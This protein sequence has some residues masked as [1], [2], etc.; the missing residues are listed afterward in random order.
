MPL[1]NKNFHI[2]TEFLS[3]FIMGPTLV[4][5]GSKQTKYTYKYILYLFAL[6][7]FIIDGYLLLQ[8]NKW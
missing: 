6:L 5:I 3:V 1:Q 8:Y 7:I 4:Y 2:V